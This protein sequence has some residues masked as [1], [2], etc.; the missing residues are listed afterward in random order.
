MSVKRMLIGGFL[1]IANLLLVMFTAAQAEPLP[2]PVVSSADGDGYQLVEGDIMLPVSV[3]E[4]RAT[5]QATLWTNKIVPYVFHSSVSETNRNRT[6]AA[7]DD[8]SEVS[9]LIFVP[10]TSQANYIEIINSGSVSGQPTGNWSFVGMVGGR[11]YLSMYNWDW[12]YIIMHELAHALGF[13]HEQSRPDRDTYVTI[14]WANITSGT[15]HNFNIR[16]SASTVGSYDFASIMHYDDY[17]FS[18]NGQRT[19]V[20]KAGYESFQNVMGNRSYLTESDAAG[21]AHLYPTGG[22]GGGGGG[23]GDTRATAIVVNSDNFAYSVATA[24]FTEDVSDPVPSS[25]LGI[26]TQ[27]DTVWFKIE[28]STWERAAYIA[29]TGYDTVLSVYTGTPESLTFEGC[30]DSYSDTGTEYV[31]LPLGAALDYYIQVGGWN[32]SSGTLTFEAYIDPSLLSNGSFDFGTSPWTIKSNPSTRKDD[33]L[34]TGYKGMSYSWAWMQFKGGT[35]ENSTLKQI[36]LPSG[37]GF[38]VGQTYLYGGYVSSGAIKNDIFFK[39]TVNYANGTKTISKLATT[40]KQSGWVWRA[41]NITLARSDVTR[42]IFQVT[43]KSLG[44]ATKIDNLMML[45]YGLGRAS[46]RGLMPAP[47][48]SVSAL[49]PFPNSFETFR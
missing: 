31:D 27:T 42:I 11:Q 6:R 4:G 38:T 9:G 44:G 32:G 39:V 5:Y 41:G 23:E 19:I 10:R 14:Q 20:A 8:W 21:M 46:L 15:E 1:V 40:G 37:G 25:C 45:P 34:K 47:T 12:H 22:G 24:D 7:M 36:Y 3:I 30:S 26:S 17:S 43:N 33:A 2:L 18:S 35:G 49:Q 28:A 48:K 29:A 16:N 13:W